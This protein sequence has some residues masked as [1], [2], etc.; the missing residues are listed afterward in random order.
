VADGQQQ[1]IDYYYGTYLPG[2]AEARMELYA[3]QNHANEVML[4]VVCGLALS[5]VALAAVQLF[6]SFKLQQNP[7]ASTLETSGTGIKI[8]S[9]FV[10]VIILFLSF[11]FFLL[12]VREVYTIKVPA[13]GAGYTTGQAQPSPTLPANAETKGTLMRSSEYGY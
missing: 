6:W 5:G 3:W 4:W 9:P 7:Q 13:Q 12:F 2:M 11:S 1:Y 10:G 8:S